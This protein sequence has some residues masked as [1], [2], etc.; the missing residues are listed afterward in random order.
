MPHL[1]L[2][3]GPAIVRAAE[4]VAAFAALLDSHPAL[5]REPRVALA[6]VHVGAD[7]PVDATAEH[8][9]ESVEVDLRLPFVPSDQAVPE[10]VR[11][12]E[13]EAGG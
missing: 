11:Q 1:E 9:A 12:R 3:D 4:V 8:G 10:P 7:F 5:V 13:E 6:V 2:V